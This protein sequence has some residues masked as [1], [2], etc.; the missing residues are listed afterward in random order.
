MKKLSGF[1]IAIFM[2]IFTA[3]DNNVPV[4]VHN[5][6]QGSWHCVENSI[7]GTR[8]YLIDIDP[9]RTDTT[10][11]LISNF[12][13]ITFDG[14]NMVNTKRTGSTLT[15][16]PNQSITNGTTTIIVK[17]GTGVISNAF[18]RIDFVYYIFDGHNDIQVQAAYTR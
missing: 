5:S 11:Y 14:L 10:Q 2:L 3:C 9:L 1:V 18:K 4:P 17:S 15:I 7:N 6:L 8:T 13:N 16:V 12:Q